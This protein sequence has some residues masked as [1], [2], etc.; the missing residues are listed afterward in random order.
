MMVG[1]TKLSLQVLL[2]S[3]S[4][5]F[6]LYLLCT[7]CDT[8]PDTP[9]AQQEVV[10]V[11]SD[12]TKEGLFTSGIE[13]PAYVDG[14]IYAVNFDTQGTIGMVDADGSCA[15]FVNL[16]PG[17]IGNGIR[18]ND[19][20]DLF[21]ADYT[22]HNV[23][24]IDRTSR[25]IEV[26]AHSDSMNQPNDLAIRSDGT[27]FA[28]D[29]DWKGGTGQLWRIDTDGSVHLLERNMGTSNGVEVSADEKFLYVNESVQRKVW[30]YNLSDDGS[31][32]GK[33]LF[34]E[35]T[36]FGMDGMRCD[37]MGNLFITRHGKGTVAILNT[38]GELVRE[39]VLLGK[40]PSN[41]AFGSKDG[42]TCF[43]TLQDRG[44]FESFRTE[45]PG[46]SFHLRMRN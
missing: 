21:I 39:V 34:H 17:S 45:Y 44:C 14:Y 6:M 41:I 42:R 38:D 36:D 26:F 19:L 2:L 43:V 15:L 7:G 10:Y 16:P 23:L 20:G 3:G 28:S 8:K 12:F 13:G 25:N 1:L 27:L 29:P 4:Y 24:K 46:R 30:R 11:A 40:K 18:C 35:F 9:A 37:Q 32:S 33:M 31:I 5:G 22:K